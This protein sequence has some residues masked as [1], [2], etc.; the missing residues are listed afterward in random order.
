[1][2]LLF[3]LFLIDE[4][5]IMGLYINGKLFNLIAWSTTIMVSILT[6]LLVVGTIIP[7]LEG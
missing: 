1:M 5:K 3:T 6:V 4:R 7:F 2:V